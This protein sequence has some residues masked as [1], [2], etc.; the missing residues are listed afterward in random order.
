MEPLIAK[1]HTGLAELRTKKPV[2]ST[3]QEPAVAI[4]ASVTP[5]YS[6]CLEDGKPYKIFRRHLMK[7]YALTPD[8]YRAK[9]NFLADYPV[10][11]P[12]YAAERSTTAFKARLDR[13]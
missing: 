13:R 4:R 3:E 5:D 7:F 6:V 1:T 8:A 12:N 2:R 10:V 9:W 11:A